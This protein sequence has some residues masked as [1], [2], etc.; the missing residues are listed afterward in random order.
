VHGHTVEL[1]HELVPIA[2]ETELPDLVHADS[3][4]AIEADHAVWT[5]TAD[6]TPVL[7]GD[8]RTGAV[9]AIHA[10]WRGTAA[11]I[12]AVA[13]ATLEAQG[14]DRAD[15]R[16]ALGPAISGEVYQVTRAV[17]ATVAKTVLFPSTVATLSPSL[18]RST[19]TPL[20]DQLNPTLSAAEADEILAAVGLY[21]DN[22]RSPILPD[23]ESDKVRLDVRRGILGQLEVLGIAPTAIAIAPHCTYQ[24]PDRFFSYRRTGEKFVQWSGI[25][26]QTAP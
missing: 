17:A 10:G 21:P 13:I 14:S 12:L 26:S 1:S 25:V 7:V 8:V 22:P 16:F 18:A 20:D 4:V 24:D 5:C 11:Q 15:L 9:S 23:P 19:V 3:I 6:C 2:P